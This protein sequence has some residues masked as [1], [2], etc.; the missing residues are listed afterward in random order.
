[1]SI[2]TGVPMVCAHERL[3]SSTPPSARDKR[4]STVTT[5]HQGEAAGID[6][7]RSRRDPPVSYRHYEG[8]APYIIARGTLQ[9]DATSC[10]G[11]RQ[12][13]LWSNFADDLAN[14][15]WANSHSVS[16]RCNYTYRLTFRSTNV[17]IRRTTAFTVLGMKCIWSST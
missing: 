1:M 2:F 15:M 16:Q 7:W 12:R 8:Q 11:M 3:S 5:G 4:E 10:N 17:L 9:N 13:Q 14:E 6:M